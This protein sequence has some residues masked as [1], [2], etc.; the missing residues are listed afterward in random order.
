MR[1]EPVQQLF[2]PG[3]ALLPEGL[4]ALLPLILRGGQARGRA[5]KRAGGRAGGGRR[6]SRLAAP[7]FAPGTPRHRLCALCVHPPSCGPSSLSS[8]VCGQPSLKLLPCCKCRGWVAAPQRSTQRLLFLHSHTPTH[9]PSP[10]LLLLLLLG[11]SSQCGWSWEGA[12]LWL[13]LRSTHAPLDRGGSLPH[14]VRTLHPGL[15]PGG[16]GGQRHARAPQP[17]CRHAMP[18]AP[19]GSS[20]ACSR[21]FS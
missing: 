12:R 10:P 3:G 18:L 7:L 14:R 17:L 20:R 16:V 13:L 1:L 9:T 5:A 21:P 2:S 8:S 19:A 11:C 4:R 15:V 6:P